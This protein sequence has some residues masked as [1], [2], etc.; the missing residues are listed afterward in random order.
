MYTKNK[1]HVQLLQ[2]VRTN[3]EMKQRKGLVLITSLKPQM[4]ID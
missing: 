1:F 2:V 4:S 3:I